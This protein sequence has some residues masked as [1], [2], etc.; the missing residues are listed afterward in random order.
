MGAEG[1]ILAAHIPIAPI[2]QLQDRSEI[3]RPT[4]VVQDVLAPV[5]GLGGL[6]VAV[7]DEHIALTGGEAQLGHRALTVEHAQL[8]PVVEDHQFIT[9]ASL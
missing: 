9:C 7:L 3:S 5:H 4:Q 2:E 8:D 1:I 6:R